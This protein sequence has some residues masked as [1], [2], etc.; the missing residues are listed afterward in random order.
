[1]CHGGSDGAKIR[2]NSQIK[3]AVKYS[4][5]R[6]KHMQTHS[7]ICLIVWSSWEK[8]RSLHM[9][10]FLQI[11]DHTIGHHVET[12]VMDKV[13]GVQT[14]CWPPNSDLTISFCPSLHSYS[15][16]S[17]LPTFDTV[18]HHCNHWKETPSRALAPFFLCQVSTENP[19][20]CS[21]NLTPSP[22]LY[23]SSWILARGKQHEHAQA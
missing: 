17:N 9:S 20:P 2:N 7:R 8:S 1:M 10:R 5:L 11:C 23:Q 12:R 21:P 4:T 15:P 6:E 14:L 22:W 3:S 19:N 16:S 13:T 18:N